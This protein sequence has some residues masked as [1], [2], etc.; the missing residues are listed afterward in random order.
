MLASVALT[1]MLGNAALAAPG[2][3]MLASSSDGGVQGN[4]ESAAADISA[5]GRRVAFESKATNFDSLD[6]DLFQDIYVKDL[7]SGDVTLAS[8]A[9]PR[10]KGKGKGKGSL[11]TKGNLYSLRPSLS[12]DGTRVAFDTGSY[13][14]LPEDPSGDLDIYVKD[15]VT[16]ALLLASTAADG[17][18]ANGSSARASISDDGTKV[19]FQSTATNLDPADRD[20]TY[21]VYVKD[22]VTGSV[23]L[24]SVTAGGAKGN[25]YSFT[26]AISPDGTRVAFSS[27]ATNLNPDDPDSV[28]DLYVKDLV[29][30]EL[31]LASASDQGKSGDGA[32]FGASLSRDGQV[33]AFT[34]QAANLDPGDSQPWE[35]VYVKDLASGDLTLASTAE[36]GTKGNGLSF[37][38]SISADGRLVVFSSGSTN[39]SSADSDGLADVF[40]KDLATGAVSLLSVRA[41]GV[42]GDG[43]SGG[44]SSSADAARVAFASSATNLYPEATGRSQILVKER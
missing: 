27:Q 37:L 24:V 20:T 10:S 44:G 32:S 18:K 9:P 15:L 26:P 30:G 14:L 22:L 16:D 41:D 17:T 21:D 23:D 12:A 36:N 11:P 7:A 25:S 28:T 35:D 2:D 43:Y 19:A 31:F 38:G 13:N 33:V 42:K 5:D 4:F 40:L 29:T 6:T 1:L 3:I 34:S 8:V 39:L